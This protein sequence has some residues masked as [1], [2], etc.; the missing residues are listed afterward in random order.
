MIHLPVLQNP[1]SISSKLKTWCSK[2]TR[3]SERTP[4]GSIE[5]VADRDVFQSPNE[6]NKIL[7]LTVE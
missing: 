3:K 5:A 7:G 2:S 1:P 6:Y 4:D